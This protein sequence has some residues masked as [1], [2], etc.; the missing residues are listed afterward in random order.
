MGHSEKLK[1][2][3][4][5]LYISDDSG[6]LHRQILEIIC[7]LFGHKTGIIS[8][9]GYDVCSRCNKHE[10]YDSDYCNSGVL[11]KIYRYVMQMPINFKTWYRRKFY[12]ELPF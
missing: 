3:D 2:I 1:Q 7:Y 5:A 9:G 11:K 10:Y 4:K 6:S 8:D 12:N